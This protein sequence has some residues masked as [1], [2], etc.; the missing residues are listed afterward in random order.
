VKKWLVVFLLVASQGA[1]AAYDYTGTIQMVYTGP[2]YGG[3]VFIQVTSPPP[4]TVACDSDAVLD[5]VFDATT[6]AGKISLSSIL[7][8]YA[9]G[10]VVRLTST[11]QCTLYSGVPNLAVVALK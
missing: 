6:P 9:G 1:E 2:T 8:A 5:F 3:L 10:N 11:D 4:G 7:T